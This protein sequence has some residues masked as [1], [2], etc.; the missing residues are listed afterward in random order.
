MTIVING[1]PLSCA[2]YLKLTDSDTLLGTS[3]LTTGWSCD[4]TVPATVDNCRLLGLRDMTAQPQLFADAI[5]AT[6]VC[7]L[8]TFSAELYVEAVR[9]DTIDVTIYVSP[10]GFGELLRNI[11]PQVEIAL[12]APY[13]PG[14]QGLDYG[15]Y[16]Y[17]YGQPDVPSVRCNPTYQLDA[18][19]YQLEAM[20][21]VTASDWRQ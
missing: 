16:R 9:M 3:S 8:G 17:N 14:G 15:M 10:V 4:F 1:E 5:E 2:E 13:M 6:L 11:V 19:M 18:L 20:N 7:D 21:L 12:N